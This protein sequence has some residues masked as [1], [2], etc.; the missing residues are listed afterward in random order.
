MFV[1]LL[2]IIISKRDFY[3]KNNKEK[4]ASPYTQINDNEKGENTHK[5]KKMKKSDFY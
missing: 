4:V 5:L 2:F 3:E 1:I